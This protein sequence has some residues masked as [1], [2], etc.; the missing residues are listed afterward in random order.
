MKS[1][2]WCC[3][4][5]F[6]FQEM[7]FHQNVT[8]KIL[9]GWRKHYANKQRKIYLRKILQNDDSKI[10]KNFDTRKESI[11]YILICFAMLHVKKFWLVFVYF[12]IICQSWMF[13]VCPGIQTMGT[14]AITGTFK[15]KPCKCRE[16]I[17]ITS[18]VC[19][20]LMRSQAKY[21]WLG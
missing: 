3:Q 12:D 1:F 9:Q 8:C 13:W 6:F 15:V 4:I 16:K 21:T 18:M 17:Y 2:V 10:I 20:V 19:Q 11:F 5:K 7:Y 14:T